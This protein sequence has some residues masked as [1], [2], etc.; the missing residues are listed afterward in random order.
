MQN[1]DRAQKQNLKKKLK[2]DAGKFLVSIFTFKSDSLS[3]VVTLY[4]YFNVLIKIKCVYNE[5]YTF[6]LH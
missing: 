3:I 5:V 1:S 2:F 6:S 4:N